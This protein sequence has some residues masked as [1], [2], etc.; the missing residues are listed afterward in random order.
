MRHAT[1]PTE[2]TAQSLA[3]ACLV[4]ALMGALLGFT[5]IAGSAAWA[6]KV[7]FL[8]FLLLGVLAFLKQCSP[9]R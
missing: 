7:A 1:P 4:V 9:R 8:V 2:M 5:G 3:L 6:A